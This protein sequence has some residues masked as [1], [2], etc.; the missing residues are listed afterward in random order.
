MTGITIQ[1]PSIEADQ[2]IEV[3]V[4]VNGQKKKYHYRIEIFSWEE[5][6]TEENRALCLRKM[7]DNHEKN[8]QLIHIG[9]ATEQSVPLMFR[10]MN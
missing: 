6:E 5:C 2:S 8:W 4:K 1:L 10:Q 9:A 7:L 3:E